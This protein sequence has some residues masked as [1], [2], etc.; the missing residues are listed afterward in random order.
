MTKI[1]SSGCAV[2]VLVLLAACGNDKSREERAQ[3]AQR[4]I[5]QGAQKER[6]L[7]EGVQ[8]QVQDLDKKTQEQKAKN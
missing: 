1:I 3:E 4:A 5:Q 8:K 2:L 7:Y 6:Q